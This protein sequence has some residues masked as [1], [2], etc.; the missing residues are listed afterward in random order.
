[1]SDMAINDQQTLWQKMKPAATGKPR[2]A[3]NSW[4]RCMLRPEWAVLGSALLICPTVLR[5]Q[6]GSEGGTRVSL[7]AVSGVPTTQVMVPV[8]LT[9]DPP[10][11]DVG[12]ISAIIGFEPQ[13]VSFVRVEEGFLLDGV[14]ADFEAE[15]RQDADDPDQS[16][17]HLEV[18]TQGEDR[19]AL[20]EGLLV[21]LVFRVND[22][23]PAGTLVDLVMEQAGAMGIESPPTEIEPVSGQGATIEIISEDAI[24]YV[25]CFFFTH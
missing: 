17:L 20:R 8:Y 22:D 12:S 9:P 6:S 2:T 3:R 13:A 15:V 19:R 1:M 11:R 16:L 10:G 25:G 7:G 14:N 5:A 24:P 23:A 18:A 4:I 21:S